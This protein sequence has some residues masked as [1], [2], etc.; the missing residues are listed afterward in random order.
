MLLL[1]HV[2][3]NVT[4]YEYMFGLVDKIYYTNCINILAYH[5]L[6]TIKASLVQQPPFDD[7]DTVN[8][9]TFLPI[10]QT[11]FPWEYNNLPKITP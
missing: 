3:E 6:Y 2:E 1:K 7:S 8:A 9:S 10:Q 4:K 5:P 11:Q